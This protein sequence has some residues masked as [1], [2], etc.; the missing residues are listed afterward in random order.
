M[1][2]YRG[3]VERIRLPDL[4]VS[5]AGARVPAHTLLTYAGAHQMT[6]ST[7]LPALGV[8]LHSSYLGHP[9][10]PESVASHLQLGPNLTPRTWFETRAGAGLP[11]SETRRRCL[12]DHALE[13]QEL[14][15]CAS[16]G[17]VTVELADHALELVDVA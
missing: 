7:A 10:A 3:G 14:L 2:R 16:G 5:V 11:V 4:A 12:Y 8:E 17:H 9:D 15:G 6:L 1:A 13:L